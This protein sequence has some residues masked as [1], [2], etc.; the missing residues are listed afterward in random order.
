MQSEYGVPVEMN[1]GIDILPGAPAVRRRFEAVPYNGSAFNPEDT[2]QIYLPTGGASTFI[3][4]HRSYLRMDVVNMTGDI[5]NDLSTSTFTLPPGLNSSKGSGACLWLD[6]SIGAQNFIRELRTYQ[7]GLPLEEITDYDNLAT[8]LAETEFGDAINSGLALQMW[9]AGGCYRPHFGSSTFSGTNLTRETPPWTTFYLKDDISPDDN[10]KPFS[11]TKY[12]NGIDDGAGETISTANFNSLVSG[13][14]YL[15][16]VF[17]KFLK[18]PAVSAMSD[19][20]YGLGNNV[21]WYT[22]SSAHSSIDGVHHSLHGRD[23]YTNHVSEL[24]STGPANGRTIPADE[25]FMI[26]KGVMCINAGRRHPNL[27]DVIVAGSGTSGDPISSVLYPTPLDGSHDIQKILNNHICNTQVPSVLPY[28]YGPMATSQNILCPGRAL[29]PQTSSLYYSGIESMGFLGGMTSSQPFWKRAVSI[30]NATLASKLNSSQEASTGDFGQPGATTASIKGI[31][32]LESDSGV[33][34]RVTVCIPIISGIVGI[35]ATKYFPSMLLASQ[36]FYIELRLADYMG[37]IGNALNS[38]CV[39]TYGA[40]DNNNVYT[41]ANVA[42]HWLGGPDSDGNYPEAPLKRPGFSLSNGYDYSAA[43]NPQG[44]LDKLYVEGKGLLT[45]SNF[46]QQTSWQLQN[47]AFVGEEIIATPELTNE[48]FSIASRQPIRWT[49]TSYRNYSQYLTCTS[50]QDNFDLVLP[51]TLQ[52][53]QRL[54]HTFRMKDTLSNPLYRRNFRVN[55]AI[56]SWQ[57]RIGAEVFPQQPH[58]GHEL[59]DMYEHAHFGLHS[60]ET[61]VEL[62]KSLHL[63]TGQGTNFVNGFSD[64]DSWNATLEGHQVMMKPVF[65]QSDTLTVA[66]AKSQAA[67]FP[68]SSSYM[69]TY[70]EGFVPD[71]STGNMLGSFLLGFDFNVYGGPSGT[72]RCGR[73]FQSDQVNMIFSLGSSKKGIRSD[74]IFRPPYITSELDNVYDD[75]EAKSDQIDTNTQANWPLVATYDNTVLLMNTIAKHD[76]VCTIMPEGTFQVA[77]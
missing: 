52:S 53:V 40:L 72:S 34:N 15:G 39:M 46:A 11:D 54:Y 50:G 23:G 63:T 38:N 77:Y 69:N 4:P 71:Y 49:T 66:T 41:S 74:G 17:I 8:V 29:M 43:V 37:A 27:D 59:P 13:P 21:G 57:Y 33:S 56:L 20:G 58:R 35:E 28:W 22:G 76:M 2:V 31:A 6:P 51:C 44:A 12:P 68:M 30:P 48:L 7:S 1:P 25:D 75:S 67:K 42:N 18:A 65:K 26:V 60:A 45:S 9:G 61:A 55:P 32:Q 10:T 19:S 62:L 73:S 16:D 36:S 14:G 3:D 70:N 5:G 47:I 24:L 64:A